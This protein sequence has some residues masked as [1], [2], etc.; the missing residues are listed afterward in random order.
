MVTKRTGNPDGRPPISWADDPDR[1]AV[2]LIA[3]LDAFDA[4]S[5][6]QSALLAA[7]LM[8][9]ESVGGDAY[10]KIVA[11]GESTATEEGRADALRKKYRTAARDPEA[12]RWIVAMASIFMLLIGVKDWERVKRE[13]VRRA[14]AIGEQTFVRDLVLRLQ[15]VISQAC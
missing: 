10:A 5:I 11:P 13:L 4:T 1:Y 9:G 2:A 7:V 6:R 8:L 14:S 15:P 3:A 12:A